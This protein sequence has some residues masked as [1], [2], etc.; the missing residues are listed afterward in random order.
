[1]GLL[2][3][4]PCP[5]LGRLPQALVSSLLNRGSEDPIGEW[6]SLGWNFFLIVFF[7]DL[8]PET[9]EYFF[10]HL[11]KRSSAQTA[12]T[13]KTEVQILQ[14]M[15]SSNWLVNGTSTDLSAFKAGQRTV[16]SPPGCIQVMEGSGQDEADT[17]CMS[18]HI[19]GDF[20]AWPS[21][22]GGIMC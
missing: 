11:Y 22:A 15:S 6:T 3:R 1:M 9:L 4:S 12:Q 19:H 2:T 13:D 18:L 7:I 16:Q 20:T 14:R 8:F 17:V 21:P 10:N 5:C